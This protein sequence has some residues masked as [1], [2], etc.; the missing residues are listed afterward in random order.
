MQEDIRISIILNICE[1]LSRYYEIKK[2]LQLVPQILVDSFGMNKSMITILNRKTQEIFIETA[3]GLTEQELAKGKYKLGEGIVGIVIENGEPFV[4]PKIAEEPLFLDKTGARRNEN[5]EDVSFICIPIKTENEVVGTLCA[6]RKIDKNHDIKKDIDFLTIVA[7]I[8][9]QAVRLHQID[10]EERP[11]LEEENKRLQDRLKDQFRPKNIIGNSKVMKQVYDLIDKIAKTNTTALILGESGVGK[12][13]VAQAIHYNS[14]RSDKPFVKFNC[15][16]LPE[17]IIESEL[18]GHEKGSFT[19][20]VNTRIG[21]FEQAEGGSI[22]LDEIGELTPS[23]QTKLLRILQEREFERVGGTQTIKTN[24]RVIA[25]TNRDLLEEI[26]KG[27]FREDLYYRLNVFPIT[28]PPLRERKTDI[29]LL[30]DFFI[31][32]YSKATGKPVKRISTPAID[33]LMCYHWPGNVRELENCIE[34]AVILTDDQVIHSY[35]LPPTLQTIQ[36]SNTRYLGTLNQK[37]ESV[38]M[39]MI[40]EALKLSN[41][42][43]SEAAKDL[44]LTERIMGLRIKKYNIN[45]KKF[46]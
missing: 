34:R 36:S 3:W 18:F 30:S 20:A 35:H 4:V 29:L 42:N 33:M 44:G 26:E 31:N 14:D 17:T 2:V 25:A 1:Y 24:I 5:K 11:H 39:E 41:G 7:T 8:I 46:K 38:E 16:A 10:H 27:K 19:N 15:A 37:L 21:R 13:L 28:I 32:K 6:D 45:V 40:M 12:E 43:I 9:A 22:F 23:V